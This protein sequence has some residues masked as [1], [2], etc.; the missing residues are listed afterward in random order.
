MAVQVPGLVRA[1]LLTGASADELL[2]GMAELA[3]VLYRRPF[4]HDLAACRS[5]RGAGVDFFPPKG[6]DV[7]PALAVCAECPARWPCREDAIADVTR[8]G[9]WGATSA[10]QRAKIRAEREAA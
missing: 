8:A 9:I 5:P 3:Q 2:E 10:R 4:W 1:H 7:R 6:G